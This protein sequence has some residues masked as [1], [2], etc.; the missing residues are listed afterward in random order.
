MER[1]SQLYYITGLRQALFQGDFLLLASLG[2]EIHKFWSRKPFGSRWIRGGN[3]LLHLLHLTMFYPWALYVLN[4][5]FLISHENNH[6]S[7]ESHCVLFFCDF[8]C[9]KF[10]FTNLKTMCLQAPHCLPTCEWGLGSGH[11]DSHRIHYSPNIVVYDVRHTP[12]GGNYIAG[13]CLQ[14]RSRKSKVTTTSWQIRLS[15]SHWVDGHLIT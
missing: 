1:L 4:H 7:L 14:R 10:L 13:F 11:S 9:F 2:L 3:Y 15:L 5:S 12:I 6:S 8:S